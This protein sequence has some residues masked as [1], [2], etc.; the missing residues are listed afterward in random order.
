M[1]ICPKE[2][3]SLLIL[4]RQSGKDTFGKESSGCGD[5]YKE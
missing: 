4:T 5:R 2:V 1:V 3:K